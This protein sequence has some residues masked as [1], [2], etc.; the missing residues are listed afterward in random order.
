MWFAPHT[1]IFLKICQVVIYVQS[2][3]HINTYKN[4]SVH[5]EI[6][7]LEFTLRTRHLNNNVML[8]EV[9]LLLVATRL[10]GYAVNSFRRTKQIFNYVMLR[11]DIFLSGYAATQ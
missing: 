2:E 7:I 5:S 11:I 3:R 6:L 9:Y 1:F 8:R 4:F 10:H